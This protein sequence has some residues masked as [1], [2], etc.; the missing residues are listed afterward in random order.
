LGQR[1]RPHG[2]RY[3]DWFAIPLT[4]AA[5]VGVGSAFSLPDL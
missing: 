2:E 5:G 3:L 4:T 1:L